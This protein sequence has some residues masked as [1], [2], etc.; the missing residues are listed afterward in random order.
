MNKKVSKYYLIAEQSTE[1]YLLGISDVG[2]ISLNF[3]AVEYF[4]IKD[5]DIILATVLKTDS[6]MSVFQG[7]SK[8]H[9]G[10]KVSELGLFAAIFH[11]TYHYKTRLIPF[12]NYA[13][14]L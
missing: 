6:I 11:T 5:S 12:L 13:F 2:L 8:K 9:T 4:C 1:N 10:E 3:P 7:N 14:R